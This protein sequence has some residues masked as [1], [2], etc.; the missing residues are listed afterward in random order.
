MDQFFN[1]TL[2]KHKDDP[3]REPSSEDLQ[4]QLEKI[5]LKEKEIE[6]QR[7]E[8]IRQ[9]MTLEKLKLEQKSKQEI[10][11]KQQEIENI[12][13]QLNQRSEALNQLQTQL[14]DMKR[15]AEEFNN[16]KLRARAFMMDQHKQ[17]Q[18]LRE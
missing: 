10:E 2:S 5:Q 11:A 9:S 13:D 12:H 15:Q 4:S 6:V 3:T 16:M 1:E 17:N 8:E 18:E 14:L 7:A